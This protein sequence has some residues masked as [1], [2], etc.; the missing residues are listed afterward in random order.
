MNDGEIRI[1]NEVTGL[2]DQLFARLDA[3]GALTTEVRNQNWW[4]TVGVDVF[5][6][7]QRFHEHFGI[8]YE[9]PVRV[10][11]PDLDKFRRE[12][13]R[14]ETKEFEDAETDALRI[15]AI[16]DLMYVLVGYAYLRGWNLRTAW[17][18]VHGANMAKVLNDADN[19]SVREVTHATDIVK[20]PGWVAPKMDDLVALPKEV[21]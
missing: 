1:F 18:R 6:D 16:C 9:G 21:A 20:P 3:L 14:E 5:K 19:T 4:V 17:Q 10:L 13:I 2:R 15:D 8:G 12:F 11:E 7:V